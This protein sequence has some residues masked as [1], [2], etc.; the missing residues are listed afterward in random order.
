M[1]IEMRVTIRDIAKRLNVSH[2]TVSRALNRPDDPIISEATR[3][4]VFETAIEMGYRPN[5]A[6]RALVTGRTGLIALWIWS[7]GL[8]DSYQA[9]VSR[10]AQLVLQQL[11]YE[12]IVTPVNPRSIEHMRINK[13]APIGVDGIIAHEAGPAIEAVFGAEYHRAIPVVC[14]GAYNWLPN[15]DQVAIDLTEGSLQAVRNLVQPGVRKMLYIHNLSDDLES[16][17]NKQATSKDPRFKAF[18]SVTTETGIEAD[19]LF[20]KSGR[21]AARRMIIE[22][23][24]AHGC[25]DALFCHNDDFAIGVYRGLCDLG[26]RVP[27]DVLIAG[28]DGIEDTEYLE[29]PIST[30]VQPIE[31]VL[32]LAWDMLRGRIEDPTLPVRKERFSP[33]FEAR[34]SSIRL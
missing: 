4:R 14:T 11:P 27:E 17:R 28:C 18:E 16:L 2:A 29:T 19:Y 1:P 25:P 8:Q 23:I 13:I 9:N 22:Y 3:A 33:Q 7:E 6:A 5:T 21:D 15:A 20:I 30:I 24:Q 32:R 12:L 34:Q 26:I 10:Y 31:S